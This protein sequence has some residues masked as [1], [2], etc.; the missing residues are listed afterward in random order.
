MVLIQYLVL[1]NI[2]RG[3]IRKVFPRN[4]SQW[5]LSDLRD[6]RAPFV[7][8]RLVADVSIRIKL[9]YTNS[10]K[11]PYKHSKKIVKIFPGGFLRPIQL[12]SN[13]V[14]SSFLFLFFLFYRSFCNINP[15]FCNIN[16]G[17]LQQK[18]K[19][20]GLSTVKVEIKNG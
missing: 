17:F 15:G 16:R 10:L 11:L 14:R 3:A 19:K 4:G 20:A 13:S 2:S 5:G 8:L 7:C 12:F 6:A 9:P 18:L 1:F